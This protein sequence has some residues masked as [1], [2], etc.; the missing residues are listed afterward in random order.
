MDAGL[1]R[2][3]RDAEALRDLGIVEIHQVA[4]HD[5]LAEFG[6]K[7][8]EQPA[9]QRR[10]LPSF[11]DRLRVPR[12]R[13]RELGRIL[14]RNKSGRAGAPAVVVDARVRGDPPDP[15]PEGARWV[16]GRK[17][18]QQ[19]HEDVLGELIGVLWRRREPVGDAPDGLAEPGHEHAPGLA[20]SGGALVNEFGIGEFGRG[21]QGGRCRFLPTV[22]SMFTGSGAS[23]F[24]GEGWS[25]P[26][27]KSRAAPRAVRRPADK[28]RERG[29]SGIFRVKRNDERPKGARFG[30]DGG[31]IAARA[32]T[33][34]TGPRD[35][36]NGLLT[37]SGVASP[38]SSPGRAGRAESGSR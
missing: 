12:R 25:G 36:V 30:R 8:I 31:A 1:H 2:A 4:K 29:I 3:E 7:L 16:V 32:P 19:A 10:L 20:S 21:E 34:R 15:G 23:R 22:S 35:F 9:H 26:L 37:S 27:M 33:G 28:A 17:H 18:G 13:G 14:L 24:S 5:R 6:R 38:G 11:R